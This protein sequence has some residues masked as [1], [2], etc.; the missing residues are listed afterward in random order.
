MTKREVKV[1]VIQH[2]WHEDASEH[3]K[4][5]RDGV[6]KASKQGAQLVL[7]QELTL[8]RYFGDKEKTDFEEIS[9]LAEDLET[10]PTFQ[11][12]STLAKEYNLYIVGSIYEKASTGKFYNTA[13]IVNNEGGLKSYTRKQHI[14]DSEGYREAY[15]FGPGDSD[16]PVH[17]LGFIKIAV[18]TCWDQWF[19]EVARIYALK[20]AELILY[21]TAIGSEPED[22]DFNTQPMWERVMVGHSTANGIFVAAANRVGFEG[23]ITFYGSSFITDAMGNII[24]KASR[25]EPEVV[26][27]TLDFEK[28]DMYRRIFP[29]LNVRQP[30]TYSLLTQ[31]Q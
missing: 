28:F 19:P 12:C 24:A 7:L 15:F 17:D 25:T 6:E 4:A 16:Y 14:P 2:K 1:G 26:V 27:A 31:K 10:G 22:K 21:P 23:L 3:A 11:L 29:F 8:H 5:I 13:I 18:P 30:E 20:G 9:K